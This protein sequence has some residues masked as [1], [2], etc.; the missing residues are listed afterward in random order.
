[1]NTPFTATAPNF[2]PQ[3]NSPLLTGA[4]TTLPTGLTVETYVGA[5]GTTDWTAGWAN[6]N[7]QQTTY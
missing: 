1:L 7:P 3:A 4:A 6:W 2:V 5:F